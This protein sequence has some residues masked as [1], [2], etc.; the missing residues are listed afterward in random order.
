[1]RAAY[2]AHLESRPASA[3]LY[4]THVAQR[5][6]P[7]PFY[8]ADYQFDLDNLPPLLRERDICR[9]PSRKYPG[10]VPLTRSAW[11]DAVDAGYI[12]KPV[13]LGPKVIAWRR[14]VILDIIKNGVGGPRPR[15]RR[16]K[17]RAKA[18]AKARKEALRDMKAAAAEDEV[19]EAS[20]T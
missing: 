13:R 4:A 3:L 9:D 12:E 5:E 1:M 18:H 7:M 6:A 8:S 10:L 16:A 11:R 2:F 19:G 17:A 15:S 20:S 14:E